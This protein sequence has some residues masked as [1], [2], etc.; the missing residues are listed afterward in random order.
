MLS[1]ERKVQ[2]Q[3]QDQDHSCQDQ[4]QDQ[5]LRSQDQEQDQD[6]SCQDQDQDQDLRSQD[7]EQD[8]DFTFQYQDPDQ[9]FQS[10]NLDLFNLTLHQDQGNKICITKNVTR[11]FTKFSVLVDS[12]ASCDIMNVILSFRQTRGL[13][14]CH[15]AVSK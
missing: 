11:L 12:I 13:S 2:D 3:D 15:S 7:Q 1:Q 4:D 8:Q 6:H 10:C 14:N 9:D 5:D